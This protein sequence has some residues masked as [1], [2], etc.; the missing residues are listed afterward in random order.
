MTAQL[1]RVLT[2]QVRR[3]RR[4]PVQAT[5]RVRALWGEAVDVL[6]SD[7]SSLGC[8]LEMAGSHTIGA[9]L[10]VQMPQMKALNATIAWSGGRYVGVAFKQPLPPAVAD[11]LVR[12][13][14]PAEVMEYPL[15]VP[16]APTP[17]P[18]SFPLQ[19][20]ASLTFRS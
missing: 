3:S 15:A 4:V 9:H 10:T 18:T 7:L 5:C 11:H 13:N 19:N 17:E 6:V 16:E 8:R 2:T 12:L 1:A 14:P 20:D